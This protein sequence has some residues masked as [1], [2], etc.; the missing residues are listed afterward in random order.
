LAVR[1]L[2]ADAVERAGSDDRRIVGIV[3]LRIGVVVELAVDDIAAEE[4]TRAKP[5]TLASPRRDA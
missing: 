1:W 5:G 2:P 3:I 4:A